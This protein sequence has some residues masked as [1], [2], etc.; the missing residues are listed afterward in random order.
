MLGV[1]QFLD[2]A[3]GLPQFFLEP[4]D[5]HHKPGA[6]VGIACRAVWNV[7]GRRSLAVE[8]IE[9]SLSRRREHDASDERGDEARSK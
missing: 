1:L 8:D 9:L 2:P 7:G 5:A 3:V 4:I 6:I